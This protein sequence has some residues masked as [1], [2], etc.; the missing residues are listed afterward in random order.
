MGHHWR[1]VYTEEQHNLVYIFKTV[2]AAVRKMDCTERLLQSFQQEKETKT[3]LGDI[4][5]GMLTG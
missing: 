2:M 3:D 5:E 1:R 4:S